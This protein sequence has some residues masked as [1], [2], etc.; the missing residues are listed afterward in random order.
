MTDTL[1]P[2][3]SV[4]FTLVKVPRVQDR[5]QTVMR[6]M[7]KDPANAKALRRSQDHRRR[8]MV[9]YSRGKRPWHKRQ[10]ASKVVN[11]FEGATWSCVY[12]P[13]MAPDIKNV[14]QFIRVEPA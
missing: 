10:Q 4:T 2:G 13:D 7:R 8:N 3:Q 9:V 11:P 14:E 1:K 12:T 6:L 5:L